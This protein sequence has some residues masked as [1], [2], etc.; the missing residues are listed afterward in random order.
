MTQS[1]AAGGCGDARDQTCSLLSS[2]D[3]ASS[4]ET[5]Q[6]AEFLLFLAFSS[7]ETFQQITEYSLL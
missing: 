6:G 3:T 1:C 4:D 5:L 2:T 7:C